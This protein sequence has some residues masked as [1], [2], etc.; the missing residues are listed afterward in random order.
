LDALRLAADHAQPID[1]LIT[2]VIMPDMSGPELANRMRSMRP[3]MRTL[4]VSGYTAETLQD[5]GGLPIGTRFLEKPFTADAL[6]E[7]LRDLL[8]RT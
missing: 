2:D 4:F 5:R 8:D 1:A 7:S 3:G 6:L